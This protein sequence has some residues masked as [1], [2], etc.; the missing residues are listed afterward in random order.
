MLT[1]VAFAIPTGVWALTARRAESLSQ[2]LCA[3]LNAKSNQRPN[4]G[5]GPQTDALLDDMHETGAPVAC[6]VD[7]SP[8]ADSFFTETAI[9]LRPTRGA[10]LGLRV[11]PLG[12]APAILGYWTL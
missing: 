7:S 8:Y 5:M 10:A 11:A 4:V 1:A 12:D 2:D 3:W 9:V 6:E